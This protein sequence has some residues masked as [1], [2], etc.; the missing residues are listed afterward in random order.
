M[1]HLRQLTFASLKCDR[2]TRRK[3]FLERMDSLIPW[4][5]LEACI[6][7]VYP[8]GG[9]A[10][11]PR[12]ATVSRAGSRPSTTTWI[13]VLSTPRERPMAWSG[14]PFFRPRRAGAQDVENPADRPPVVHPRNAPRLV[15][16][17][18]RDDRPFRIRQIVLALHPQA[19]AVWKLESHQRRKENPFP[20]YE[21]TT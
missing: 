7:P 3:I 19:P 10:S 6:A 9:G 17:Q 8:T 14:P 4:A 20:L 12:S 11:Q 18:R 16:R 5:R 13:L 21:Y 1:Q 2:K 15:R